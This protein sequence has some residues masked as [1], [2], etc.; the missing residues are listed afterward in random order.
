MGY[1]LA[2]DLAD[3]YST[4]VAL[5]LHLRTNFYPPVPHKMASVCLDAIQAI[6]DGDDEYLV[7]LPEGVLW[8]GQD[9]APAWSV[10][11]NFRLAPWISE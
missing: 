4:E 6:N 9:S 5:E 2:V 10:A 11:E 3:N 8:R 7:Q 1:A